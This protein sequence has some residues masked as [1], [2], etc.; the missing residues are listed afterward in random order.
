[1]AVELDVLVSRLK[2]KALRMED[3]MLPQE[4]ELLRK[5]KDKNYQNAFNI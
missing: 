2:D 4:A 5:P 1:M 3:H